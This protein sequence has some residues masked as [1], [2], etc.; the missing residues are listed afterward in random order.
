MNRLFI[1]ALMAIGLAGCST[2]PGVGPSA[3]DVSD[4]AASAEASDP[5]YI[6]VDLNDETIR[7][8]RGRV[9]GYTLA[10]FR[11][12]RGPT[13]A[14][15]GVGD[16]VSLT[17]WEA[18]AGGL[19]SNPSLGE[20]STSGAKSAMIPEQMVG[21]DGAIT[22]PYA[23]RVRAA[24]RTTQDIQYSIERALDGKAIQPQV[25]VSVSKPIA[26]T[27]TVLGEATNG[28]RIP[29]S[30]KGDRVLDVIAAAG[31][32]RAPVNETFVQ[33]SRGGAT[34]RVAL[35]RVAAHPA[36]NIY[37]RPGDVLTLIRDPQV[38]LAY[39]ATG[40]NADISFESEGL[41][42]AQALSKSGGLQD[43]RADPAG[44]FVFRME[45]VAFARNLSGYNPSAV[46]GG[47]VKVVYRL[48]MRDP[49]SMFLASQFSVLNRDL[50][51]VSNAPLA[52]AQ[53]VLMLFN[54]VATPASTGVNL[55]SAVK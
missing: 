18:G 41:N 28:G 19:F 32:V 55:A 31:G 51:Y 53:K 17:I 21:R 44:V 13:D 27:V 35:S 39:G 36:E 33:L 9:S 37:V 11:D 26:N 47:S 49:N 3:S 15:V 38:F 22:V 12:R 43:S 7:R 29:L 24:G 14:R 25:L 42:L 40:R 4:S 2:L 48:N 50:L 5:R 34:A 6:L 16:V 23:G 8:L 54:L 30:P 10:S 1:A 46:T 45:P 52:E 20:R